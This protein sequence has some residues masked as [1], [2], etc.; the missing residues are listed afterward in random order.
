MNTLGGGMFDDN[1]QNYTQ[2]NIQDPVTSVIGDDTVNTTVTAPT[3]IYGDNL[4]PVVEN[5]QAQQTPVVDNSPVTDNS[6]P[7][8]D[9]LSIKKDA[10][11]K[12]APLI[13]Q[14]DQSPE[15]KFK[16]MLMMIQ[17]SDDKSLLST[18]YTVAQSITD[19]KI[20]AQALLDIVNEINYFTQ[21][22]VS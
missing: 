4:L 9:L 2:T 19:E 13:N 1:N 14:L 6:L 15:E 12:L 11:G 16:T 18:A 10:L 22:S 5:D 17:A 8:D 7:Y 20:R 3:P 21:P